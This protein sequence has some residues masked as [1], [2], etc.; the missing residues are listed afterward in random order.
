MSD[1]AT[2]QKSMPELIPLN[3]KGA[4]TSPAAVPENLDVSAASPTE[5]AKYGLF[6]SRPSA[7]KSGPADFLSQVAGQ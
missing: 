6:W 4:Y 1:Q 5:L 3:I 2:L 7:E